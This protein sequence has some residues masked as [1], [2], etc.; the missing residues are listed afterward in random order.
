MTALTVGLGVSTSPGPDTNPIDEA[1]LA[2]S[3]GFDFVSA[4]DHLHGE[5]P[6]YEPWSL[7]TW[8]AASTSRLRVA[9]RVLAVPYRAPAVTAKMAETVDRLSNGRLILGLGAGYLDAEFLAFGLPASS[10]KPLRDKIDGMEEAIRLIRG[11]WT[12]RQTTYGGRIYHSTAARLEP[13]PLHPIPIWLGTYGARALDITGR[14]AD[15]WIPSLGLASPDRVAEMRDQVRRS[16]ERADRDPA[17]IAM[18]Y[19]VVVHLTDTVDSDERKVVGPPESV[20]GKL[21]SFARIGFSGLN[22]MPVGPGIADQIE[23]LG[24]EVLPHLRSEVGG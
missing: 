20:I 11:L 5:T 9:T 15:G 6:T 17:S 19:N 1:I 10:F 24:Q 3:V 16:A 21:V 8:I 22:L 7:L 18:I 13:K 2:E 23:R 4:S 12:Q 14:L